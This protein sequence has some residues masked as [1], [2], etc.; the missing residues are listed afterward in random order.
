MDRRAL[1]RDLK[2]EKENRYTTADDR[3][4]PLVIE[5]MGIGA[6]GMEVVL[7]VHEHEQR[8]RWERVFKRES[9]GDATAAG[10]DAP[11]P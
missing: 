11:A 4:R 3:L 8:V 2:R 9:L 10:S 1:R 5:N 6:V 7:L